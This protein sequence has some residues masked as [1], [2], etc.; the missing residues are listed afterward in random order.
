MRSKRIAAP[1]LLL[2]LLALGGCRAVEVG[3]P[4]PETYSINVTNARAEA[5]TVYFDDGT[6]QRLLGTVSA[7]RSE[8]F[9]IAG[10]RSATVTIIATSADG[11]TTLR[12]TVTLAP[13][14]TINLKLET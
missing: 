14:E 12:Q 4:S 2:T 9:I 6:G 13:G 5:M 3:G 8:R 7:G 10:A 11:D 1:A